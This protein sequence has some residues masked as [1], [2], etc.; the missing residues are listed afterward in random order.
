[1]AFSRGDV[2]LVRYPFTDLSSSKTRPAVVVSGSLYQAQQPDLM[3]AALTSNVAAATET[4]DYV[5]QDWK[6]ANLRFPTAF[7]P[8]V[9]TLELGLVVFTIGALS[10]RDLIE[11]ENRL[12][13]VLELS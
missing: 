12:R 1:M 13:D 5:L 11:I 4:L 10:G 2:V 6:S 3:L 9:A 8:V 7:K